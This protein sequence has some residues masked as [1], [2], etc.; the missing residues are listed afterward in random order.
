MPLVSVCMTAYNHE[1]YIV[2]AIESILAQQAAFDVELVIGEDCSTDRTAEI[3][4]DYAAKYPDRVRLV[5][6]AQN[7]GMHA[8]YRRTIEA[9]RGRYIALCDG[10]DWWCDPLKLQKQVDMLESEPACGVC[11]TRSERRFEATGRAEV[12]PPV[13]HTDFD[14]ML[15]KN[16]VENCTAVARREQVLQYY[17]EVRPWEHPEWLTDDQP[18]WIWFACRSRIRMLDTVTA[19]HRMLPQSVSQSGQYRRKI[20]FCDSL[21]DIGLWFDARYG[22]GRHAFGLKRKRSSDALWVL[23]YHGPV[24]EYLARWRRDVAACPRLVL[25]PEGYGLL[26][27]KILFRRSKNR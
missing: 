10:D 17:A 7:V 18:M 27:K 21:M 15:F 8:N 20:A 2:Q 26:V 19:V 1:A 9:C 11:C 5:T 14:R 13:T 16:T 25:C 23:S 24:S 3:C 12:Y 22:A 4:R 6:S